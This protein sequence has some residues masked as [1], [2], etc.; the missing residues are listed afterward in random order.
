[1]NPIS[2]FSKPMA[3]KSRGWVNLVKND[4]KQPQEE[5]PMSKR[6]INPN[7]TSEQKRKKQNGRRNQ[8]IIRAEVKAR[9][10]MY[11]T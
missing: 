3:A 2:I 7:H 8:I 10:Q 1:M 4:L 6:T 9:P 11:F 5:R